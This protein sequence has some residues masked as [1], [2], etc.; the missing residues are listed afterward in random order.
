MGIVDPALAQMLH[1]QTER[2]GEH[3]R[4]DVPGRLLEPEP[5]T[6]VPASELALGALEAVPWVTGRSYMH[7]GTAHINIQ[8]IREVAQEVDELSELSLLSERACNLVDSRVTVGA[9]AKGRSSSQWLNQSIRAAVGPQLLGHKSVNNLWG[10]SARN[11]SDDPSRGV[12]LRAPKA[13]PASLPPSW[14][15]PVLPSVQHVIQALSARGLVPKQPDDPGP[16][17]VLEH[18]FDETEK[19][20]WS[21]VV[22]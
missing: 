16:C 9:W 2:R 11:P 1:E 7:A 21:K 10:P 3:N 20:V 8:E 18:L 19:W 17:P 15:R 5:S 13:V 14:V 6:M 4:L 22:S 12:P